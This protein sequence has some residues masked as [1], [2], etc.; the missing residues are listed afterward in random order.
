MINKLI[1]IFLQ[2]LKISNYLFLIHLDMILIKKDL[3]KI[4]QKVQKSKIFYLNNFN[5]TIKNKLTK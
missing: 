1:M 2:L 3:S 5:C 4:R